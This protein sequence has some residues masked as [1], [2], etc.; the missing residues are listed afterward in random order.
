[1]NAW[2]CGATFHVRLSRVRGTFHLVNCSGSTHRPE[3][4]V[5]GVPLG[6]ARSYFNLSLAEV[7]LPAGY[8]MYGKEPLLGCGAYAAVYSVRRAPQGASGVGHD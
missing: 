8:E 3:L 2:T 5:C 7:E 4:S 1:M 6:F